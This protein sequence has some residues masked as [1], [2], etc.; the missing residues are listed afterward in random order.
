MAK[1]KPVG[2]PWSG[3][4]KPL[5]W[6]TLEDR[7]LY[8]VESHDE[9]ECW[10]WKRNKRDGYGRLKHN[11]ALA[12]AHRVAYELWVGPI[13]EELQIDH[14]CRNRACI[15]PAHLEPVTHAENMR[16]GATK[17]GALGPP[18]VTH[19]KHG[20]EFTPENTGWCAGDREG[21]R[22]CRKCA[23]RRTRDYYWRNREECCA[24]QRERDHRKRGKT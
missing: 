2:T 3:R 4:G 8:G 20:H 17:G 14:L 9:G 7:L 18:P 19:C 1:P 12:N 11:G 15:N 13:P 16:R 22:Y 24:K 5:N 21:Q 6:M 10:I 23:A